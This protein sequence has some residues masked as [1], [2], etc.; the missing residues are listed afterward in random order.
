MKT[1]RK[2]RLCG[3]PLSYRSNR[4]HN[5]CRKCFLTLHRKGFI[6][7]NPS[8]ESGN[9]RNLLPTMEE[10]T[11]KRCKRQKIEV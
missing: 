4:K 8:S 3:K 6:K 5:L 10:D 2:C 1:K 9:A 7:P 11:P